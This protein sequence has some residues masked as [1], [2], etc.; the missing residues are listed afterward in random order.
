MPKEIHETC[1]SLSRSDEKA[2]KKRRRKKQRQ[3][4][5]SKAKPDYQY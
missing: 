4:D 3:L 2:Q 5:R 1:H